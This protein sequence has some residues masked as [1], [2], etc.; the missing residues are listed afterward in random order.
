MSLAN[1]AGKVAKKNLREA[2]N[3]IIEL[4]KYLTTVQEQIEVRIETSQP[5]FPISLIDFVMTRA[6]SIH[7]KITQC[8]GAV[9]VQEEQAKKVKKSSS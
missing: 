1:A 7:T 5:D 6:L 4:Q 8:K 9:L 3:E 2:R